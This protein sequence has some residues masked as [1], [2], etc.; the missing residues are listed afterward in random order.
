M[1]TT[2]LVVSAGLLTTI[3]L[4]GCVA[5][6]SVERGVLEAEASQRALYESELEEASYHRNKKLL[7]YEATLKRQERQY[8][9]L[10]DGNRLLKGQIST[11]NKQLAVGKKTLGAVSA[12]RV[13]VAKK[14]KA[15]QLQVAAL[16]KQNQTLKQQALAYKGSLAK[17][18]KE[19]SA[20]STQVAA[21]RKELALLKTNTAG[22]Q[23]SLATSRGTL[24]ALSS[25]KGAMELQ[26]KQ[27]NN[28]KQ[29][30]LKAQ[31]SSQLALAK[32]RAER[33]AQL[34]EIAS[35]E[36][37]AKS[38]IKRKQ[39][40]TGSLTAAKVEIAKLETKNGLLKDRTKG[41]R[42]KQ[43]ALH[44]ELARVK[45]QQRQTKNTIQRYAKQKQQATQALAKA[46]KLQQ[47]VKKISTDIAMLEGELLQLGT[48]RQALKATRDAVRS[49]VVARLKP[50][51]LSPS[52]R[53]KA[54][55]STPP[56]AAPS[57]ASAPEA[58]KPID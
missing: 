51:K 8:E 56:A 44:T 31:S 18:Q 43:D 19:S 45:V 55:G 1:R 58:G 40:L 30:L 20:L 32:L 49:A 21:Q 24:A 53:L 35:L 10:V 14:V 25:Q 12:Q 47:R 42:A 57:P 6:N 27:I 17:L 54:L 28:D 23:Q 36:V 22:L 7:Q 52:D 16:A 39:A 34:K 48:E 41:E 46:S 37:S 33:D 5:P 15:E 50:S 9:G 26:I 13:A 38:L 2:N 29:H 3:S 4:A 11:E